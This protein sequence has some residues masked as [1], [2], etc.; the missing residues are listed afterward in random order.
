MLQGDFFSA[1]VSSGQ[2]FQPTRQPTA[3]GL[4][5]LSPLQEAARPPGALLAVAR[6]EVG[7]E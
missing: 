2:S 5:G 6:G 3:L 4:K 7:K 1:V